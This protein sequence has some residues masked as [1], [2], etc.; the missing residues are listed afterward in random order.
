MQTLINACTPEEKELVVSFKDLPS[1]AD[2]ED[3][4][5]SV[6]ARLEMMSGGSAQAVRTFENREEQIRKT[7][8]SLEKHIADLEIAQTTIKEIRD[9]FETELDELI[10]RISEAFAHNFEQIG[11]AGE[12]TVYKDDDD[13]NAWAI[14]IS[15][16]FR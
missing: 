8:D 10:T 3:E 13:F 9:P 11:C 6:N 4:I 12:V 2:L 15:V 1:V 14:Q 16:R 5:Q 7:K